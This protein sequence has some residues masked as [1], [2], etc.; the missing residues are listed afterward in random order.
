MQLK[1]QVN[2][3]ANPDEIAAVEAGLQNF[4]NTS[5]TIIDVKPLKVIATEKNGEVA[6]GA[7]GRTWGE[8]CELQQ[9]WVDAGYRCKGAGTLLMDSFEKEAVN[10]KCKLIYLETFT[11]QGPMFY[12]KR[13]YVEVLRIAGFGGGEEKIYMQKNISL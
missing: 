11:F 12:E 4:N 3:T 1:I 7:I 10:R 6:G 9:L 2:A 13:G 5:S 8:C